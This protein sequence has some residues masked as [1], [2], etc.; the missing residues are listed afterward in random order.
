[1]L[2]CYKE[3]V[4][5][6][7]RKNIN[8][9]LA[10]NGKERRVI[11]IE[12]TRERDAQKLRVAAYCRVSSSSED[13]LNSFAAQNIHYT[14]YIMEH[15][16]W[17][18]VDIYADEGVTGTSVEKREDFKRM[19]DDS[20]RGL[21]D[22]ILVKSISRFA[23]NTAECLE[24]IRQ[25]RANGTTIFFEKE[26]IDT[27]RV[28]S[29]LMTALYAAFAQAESESISGNIRWSY[30]KRIEREEFSTYSAPLGYDLVGGKLI[31][32]EKEANVV[33][34]I[35]DMYLNGMNSEEIAHKMNAQDTLSISWRRQRIE[36]ILKTKSTRVMPYYRNP[37]QRNLFH[38]NAK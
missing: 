18:L 32:N 21:I 15:E 2:C 36:Y 26:N 30:Q 31:I 3:E 9:N 29:E 7:G 27:A 4:N 12:A 23:R 1:M 38:E 37:T 11:R 25:F 5:S 16:D 35:F 14:Q 20:G 33:R 19:L 17:R 10:L 8:G 24:A 6:H 34:E 22:R 28:S 13:Q